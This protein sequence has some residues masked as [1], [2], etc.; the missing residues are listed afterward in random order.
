MPPGFDTEVKIVVSGPGPHVRIVPAAQPIS[1]VARTEDAL[2]IALDHALLDGHEI[3]AELRLA[4]DPYLAG[5]AHALRC[6]FRAAV[7]PST[8]Y[9]ESVAPAIA[10]HLRH[11]YVTR[12]TRRP[13]GLEVQR[14]ARALSFI[15][16]H[17]GDS[18]SVRD[19]ASHVH[20]SAFHFGRMFRRSTGESPHEYL[21]RRR[22]EE[23]LLLVA[24]TMLPL[25]EVARRVG[26]PNQAH[27]TRAFRK[28]VGASPLRYR[29]A[30]RSGEDGSAAKGAAAARS[31]RLDE[32]ARTHA[33]TGASLVQLRQARLKLLTHLQEM[34][35][36]GQEL[37]ATKDPSRRAELDALHAEAHGRWSNS[38]DAFCESFEEFTRAGPLMQEFQ[39][40]R[41][42]RK[43]DAEA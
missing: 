24:R 27:F 38:F 22:M 9:L 43:K 6:G 41:P 11:T 15:E 7:P 32:S 1:F 12:R 19:T 17:L 26:Y 25:H 3:P 14:L 8:R 31:E 20:L 4:H 10:E 34:R 36:V 35:V 2:I 42:K 18:I 5:I 21:Q 40:T 33:Q 39:S 37:M 30:G 13:R 23:A 29:T 28:T 16:S